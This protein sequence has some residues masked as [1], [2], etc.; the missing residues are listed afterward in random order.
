MKWAV[1][2]GK[3]RIC[4]H[5]QVVVAPVY[6]TCDLDNL[7]CSNCENMAVEEIEED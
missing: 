1:V 2:N 5:K 7:E 4:N 6:D 3:C